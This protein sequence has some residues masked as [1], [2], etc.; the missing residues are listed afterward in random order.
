M[1]KEGFLMVQTNPNE[2]K[3][4]Y[5]SLQEDVLFISEEPDGEKL[6]V[7]NLK[8]TSI[9]PQ[10]QDLLTFKLLMSD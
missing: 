7:L 2:W 3:K 1:H 6:G 10:K 5:F 9:L 4:Q 8:L